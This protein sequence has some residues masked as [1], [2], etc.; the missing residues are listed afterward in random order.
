MALRPRKRL[1]M[2][3]GI[4]FT[5]DMNIHMLSRIFWGV[6]SVVGG[7][8]VVMSA[9][10]YHDWTY[11]LFGLP[12]CIITLEQA[13]RPKRRTVREWAELESKKKR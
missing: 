3:N 8:A 5:E 11:L 12:C 13:I 9:H 10:I 1:E 4:R 2:L 6:L 7:I